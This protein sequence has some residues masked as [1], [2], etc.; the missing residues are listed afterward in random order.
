VTPGRSA[1][2]KL[3]VVG[4]LLFL[5]ALAVAAYDPMI[6]HPFVRVMKDRATVT[7][8]AERVFGGKHP[9]KFQ[10]H[11]SDIFLKEDGV[12]KKVYYRSDWK[13]VK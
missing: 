5:S 2:L 12:W 6:D 9:G 3:S 1:W 7:F 13:Q 8:I 10:S 4:S 11:C